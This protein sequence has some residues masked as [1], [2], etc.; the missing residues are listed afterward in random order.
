M[1][2][3]GGENKGLRDP[4]TTVMGR[5]PETREAGGRGS[6]VCGLRR[7]VPQA[8]PKERRPVQSLYLNLKRCRCG[9]AGRRATWALQGALLL[10]LTPTATAR[11]PREGRWAPT[12]AE[13]RLAQNTGKKLCVR[14]KSRGKQTN[15]STGLHLREA[16]E[17][18]GAITT[19]VPAARGTE[20]G[21]GGPGHLM[22]RS[23]TSGRGW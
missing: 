20:V 1:G 14:Q 21:P 4:P 17:S 7:E 5:S 15:K 6:R 19:H 18:K 10:P 23:G 11:L 13:R 3:G 12:W 9:T 8:R 2:L 22:G 16:R